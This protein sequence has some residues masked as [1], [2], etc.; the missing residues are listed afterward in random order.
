MKLGKHKF[1]PMFLIRT[2]YCL[3]ADAYNATLGGRA[4]MIKE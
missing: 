2:S 3:L 4:T 1:E